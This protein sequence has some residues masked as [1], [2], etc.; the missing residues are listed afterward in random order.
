MFAPLLMRTELLDDKTC[1]ICNNYLNGIVLPADDPQWL[2]E[3]GQPAHPNCRYMIVPL[4]EGIDPV[5]DITP[6]D[7]IPEVIRHLRTILPAEQAEGMIRQL[8]LLEG[9]DIINARG[10]TEEDLIDLMSPEDLL[11]K[12]FG[13]E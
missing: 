7:M 3:L 13:G 1:E 9:R 12:I 8:H 4:F 5:M 2:G 10:L 11:W 6:D